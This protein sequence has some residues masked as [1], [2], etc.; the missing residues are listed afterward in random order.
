MRL[1]EFDM[2][3]IYQKDRDNIDPVIDKLIPLIHNFGDISYIITRLVLKYIFPLSV[4]K[5]KVIPKS[6][7][8]YNT[9]IHAYGVLQGTAQEFYRKM[10]APYEDLKAK[11]NGEVFPELVDDN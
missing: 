8:S 2:P 1:V 4:D 6:Q 11:E 9:L 10:L 5:L 7:T 3:Y